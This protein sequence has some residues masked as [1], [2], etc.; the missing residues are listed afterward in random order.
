MFVYVYAYYIIIWDFQSA[1]QFTKV[2]ALTLPQLCSEFG[3]GFEGNNLIRWVCSLIHITAGLY[4]GGNKIKRFG[5]GE[6]NQ[7]LEKKKK[8]NFWRFNTFGSSKW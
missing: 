2:Q 5:D 8:E 7:K 6:K 1:K 3:P 4:I